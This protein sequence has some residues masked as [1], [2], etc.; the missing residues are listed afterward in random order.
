MTKEK[1]EWEKLMDIEEK[2]IDG[3]INE[4]EYYKHYNE[5]IYNMGQKDKDEALN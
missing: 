2:F 4:K 1:E 3:D 5:I